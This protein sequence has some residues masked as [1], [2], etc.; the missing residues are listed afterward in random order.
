MRC[1]VL[2]FMLLCLTVSCG[3]AHHESVGPPQARPSESDDARVGPS[4]SEVRAEESQEA[5]SSTLLLEDGRKPEPT[6]A[7]PRVSTRHLGMH[8]GGED[9]SPEAKAPY[10]SALAGGESGFLRC[11]RQVDEPM[12]GGTFG[13]DL[14]VGAGGGAPEVR[15]I[16]QKLGDAEFEGCMKAAL[17]QVSFRQ[18]SRPTVLSYSLRFEVQ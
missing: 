10:L 11:Y 6:R 9:N 2:A 17:R 13:A 15:A 18:Q 3:A 12:D 8:I 5:L 1:S 7:L 14:Y 16:R 4:G